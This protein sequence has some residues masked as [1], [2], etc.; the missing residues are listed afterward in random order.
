[1]RGVWTS[2]WQPLALGAAMAGLYLLGLTVKPDVSLSRVRQLG[3]LRVCHPPA[4]PPFIVPDPV[5]PGEVG[6]VEAERVQRIAR[7]LGLA[8][9]W[10][11]QPN[12]YRT[13]DPDGWAIRKEACHALAGG[14]AA[15]DESRGLLELA[16]PYLSSGW[17]WVRVAEPSPGEAV[18][19]W[20]PFFG[21]SGARAEALAYLER[22]RLEPV[23]ME[24]TG[25]LVESL[26]RGS[27]SA[28]LTDALTARWVAGQLRERAGPVQAVEELP[29]FGFAVG[30][31]KGSA[32]LRRAINRVMADAVGPAG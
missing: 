16:E 22:K 30:L 11:L 15:T 23:F 32:T 5:R 26:S 4:L 1:M 7:R 12:W 28:V 2:R 24:D 20:A 13:W 17:A 8:V 10:N 29:S 6:G 3:V 19:F 9:Q 18:G 14:I 25:Q 31:W 21:L 27:V